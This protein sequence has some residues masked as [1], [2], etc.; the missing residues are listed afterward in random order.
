MLRQLM[1]PDGVIGTAQNVCG[2]RGEFGGLIVVHRA[3][4]AVIR[5]ALEAGFRRSVQPQPVPELEARIKGVLPLPLGGVKA[6]HVVHPPLHHGVGEGKLIAAAVILPHRHG[7]E[8]GYVAPGG[9]GVPFMA[10]V[11]HIVGDSAVQILLGFWS[12]NW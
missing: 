12:H 10:D 2:L 4:V 3:Q 8:R 5:T 11:G 9:S 1:I 6:V 7:Q